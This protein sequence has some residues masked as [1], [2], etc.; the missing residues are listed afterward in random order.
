MIYQRGD[1]GSYQ[2][3][4]D[5]VG[6]DSYTFDNLMPYFKKSVK[7]TPPNTQLRA[8][9]G[10]AEYVA[11]AFDASGGPLDVSYANY[12]GPFSS[13]ME[14]GM[15]GIGIKT[16]PD[17]NSGELMGAQYCSSTITPRNQK[18]ASSQTTFLEAAKNRANLK[19]YSLTRAEKIIFNSEKRATGVQIPFGSILSAKR[20]VILSAGAFQ[21]PQL[22]MVSGVG[23][24][25]QLK[26]FNIPVLADRRGVG[27]NMQDHIFFGPTYRY[28]VQ[29]LTKLANDLLYVGAQFAFDYGL[30]KRGPLTNPVC[31][32]LGW[33]KAPRNLVSSEA[34][35]VLDQFPASW[36]DIEYLSAPGYIG[37]FSNL[38]VTQPKDGYQYASILGAI[39]APLSRGS[40]TI[41]SSSTAQLPSIDPGWLTDP[42]DQSVA[43]AIYKRTRQ[44]FATDAMK[45]GLADTKE[46]FPGPKVQT[47][48]QILNT[49]R[50]TVGLLHLQSLRMLT[51]LVND[52]V[53]CI[54]HVQDGKDR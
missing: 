42:T 20:E 6:D 18:R 53:A 12:A 36:P 10:S 39:V 24:A 19:V 11:S 33:E 45:R 52:C 31:D 14:G 9:N 16:R 3:W 5:Q 30:L 51:E 41:T 27:Q 40:V 50:D 49:I 48:E 23:P 44:A 21:S 26:K 7:F 43:I 15:N 35:A 4:A 28:K 22:L 8:N 37:D 25:E 32:F 54:L 13:Y 38:F 46:Y 1:R 29:T 17:F 2:R 34:A 47:D